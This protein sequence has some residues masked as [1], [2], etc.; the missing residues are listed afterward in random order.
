M[1][2]FK[3]RIDMALFIKVKLFLFG[4]LYRNSYYVAGALRIRPSKK[5]V[6]KER[7]PM[8]MK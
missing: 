2:P 8:C 5:E 1:L 7:K 6:K 3:I 4:V